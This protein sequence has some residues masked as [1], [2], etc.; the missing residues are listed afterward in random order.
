MIIVIILLGEPDRVWRVDLSFLDPLSS[1]VYKFEERMINVSRGVYAFL[2][3]DTSKKIKGFF[4][5]LFPWLGC[6]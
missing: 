3:G 6:S 5:T 1:G 2:S 4:G